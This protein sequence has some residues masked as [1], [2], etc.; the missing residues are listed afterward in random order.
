MTRMIASSAFGHLK[1]RNW[2]RE[3]WERIV[4]HA[5]FAD[6]QKMATDDSPLQDDEGLVAQGLQLQRA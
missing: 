4:G 1:D 2:T 3:E 6:T 5:R